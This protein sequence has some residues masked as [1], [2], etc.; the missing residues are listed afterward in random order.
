MFDSLLVINVLSTVAF[1]VFRGI[2]NDFM[3]TFF[4]SDE[5]LFFRKEA[6]EKAV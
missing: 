4:A 1:F 6:K 5:A 2:S 3:S